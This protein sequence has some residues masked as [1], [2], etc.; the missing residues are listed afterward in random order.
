MCSISKA[1]FEWDP[2]DVNLLTQ[3]KKEELEMA[4]ISNPKELAKHCTNKEREGMNKPFSY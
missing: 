3:A 2:K 1:I 4:G